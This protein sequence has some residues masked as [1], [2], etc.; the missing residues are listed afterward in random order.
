MEPERKLVGTKI[1]DTVIWLLLGIVSVGVATGIISAFCN[2]ASTAV[3]VKFTGIIVAGCLGLVLWYQLYRALGIIANL[4][5]LTLAELVKLNKSGGQSTT[6][7]LED[8][9]EQLRRQTEGQRHIFE[10]IRYIRQITGEGKPPVPV[11][12]AIPGTIR[13]K[14]CGALNPDDAECCEICKN[15]LA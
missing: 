9:N 10:E 13:C 12:K 14:T 7:K 4:Q 3:A 6:Q 5:Q 15:R 2:S 11:Q 8:I 1:Q